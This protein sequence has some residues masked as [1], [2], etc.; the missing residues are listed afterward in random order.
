VLAKAN[1]ITLGDDYKAVVRKG[2][3]VSGP[4]TV[5]YVRRSPVASPAR[6]GFIVA[7]NV[8]GAV[9]RNLVRRRMKAAA[10]SLVSDVAPGTDVVVR[11]L[12]GADSIPWETLRTEITDAITA[13][14]ARR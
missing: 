6:F 1:R 4:H 3:R 11:A 5:M 13:S 7:K 8:G 12:P 10:Y 14:R 2:S 9:Q